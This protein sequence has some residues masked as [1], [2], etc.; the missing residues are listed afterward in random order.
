MPKG[1][2]HASQMEERGLQM[3][4]LAVNY[5]KEQGY[6]IPHAGA[7]SRMEF[8][9]E[10][11]KGKIK[12]GGTWFK[13][14]MK[15]WEPIDALFKKLGLDFHSDMLCKKDDQ[16]FMFEIKSKVWKKGKESFRSSELQIRDYDR[17]HNAGKVKVK[18]LTIIEKD[19][20]FSYHIYDW[21]DFEK[22]K[23]TIKLRI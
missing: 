6:E 10:R 20:K 13:Q 5:L 14:R 8:R 1:K 3:E 23:T 17:I 12:L 19:Q 9:E 16:Y 18:V 21:D 2:S 15:E 7:L 4:L 22:T 11:K